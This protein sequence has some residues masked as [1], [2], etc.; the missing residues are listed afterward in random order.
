VGWGSRDGPAGGP[1]GNF[2]ET[3]W[4]GE[5]VSALR[6]AAFSARARWPL[7]DARTLLWPLGLGGAVVQVLL[8]KH[9]A[10]KLGLV[11]FRD[12]C[13]LDGRIYPESTATVTAGHRCE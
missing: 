13:G 3:S 7:A 12:R 9:V 6:F 8:L 11:H 10:Q 4:R 5:T 2:L 1:Y